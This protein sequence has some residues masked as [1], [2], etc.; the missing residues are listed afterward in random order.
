MDKRSDYVLHLMKWYEGDTRLLYHVTNP[1]AAKGIITTDTVVGGRSGTGK[2]ISFTNSPHYWLPSILGVVRF[3]VDGH[4]LNNDYPVYPFIDKKHIKKTGIKS[5]YEFRVK[6][7]IFNFLSYCI[8]I[9][10]KKGTKGRWKVLS[11]DLKFVL[12]QTRLP[13]RIMDVM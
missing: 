1:F 12:N 2:T 13:V 9:D 8:R 4:R 7:P 3:V 10:I 6:G 11:K 5:E